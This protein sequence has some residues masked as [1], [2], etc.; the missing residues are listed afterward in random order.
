MAREEEGELLHGLARERS[1]WGEWE[2]ER[3]RGVGDGSQVKRG[4]TNEWGPRVGRD[5][6]TLCA[7]DTHQRCTDGSSASE[8][9][10]VRGW[11]T[12]Q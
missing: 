4:R 8:E 12:W 6:Q 5:A 7:H 9:R 3:E 2:R 1:V 11:V 10:T